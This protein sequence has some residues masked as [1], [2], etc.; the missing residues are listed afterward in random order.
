M[1]YLFFYVVVPMAVSLIVQSILCRKVKTGILRH[2]ALMLPI[3]S[4]ACGLTVLLT[5]SGGVFGG[6]GAIAAMLC[7]IIAF[8]AVCGY[9][10]AWLLYLAVRKR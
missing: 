10:A 4:V 6:L 8:C 7:F 5:Q 9:G 2:A 3:I 1:K